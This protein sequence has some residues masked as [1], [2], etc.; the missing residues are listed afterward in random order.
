MKRFRNT[1]FA[2]VACL[3][4]VTLALTS[5]GPKPTEAPAEEPA[6]APA[7]EPAEEPAEKPAGGEDLVFAVVP[8]IA[9]PFYDDVLAGLEEKGGELGVEFQWVAPPT[10]NP[11]EQVQ[12]LEDLINKGVNGIGL[13]PLEASSVEPVIAKA[14]EAGIPVVT[15]DSDAPES[16]RVAYFGTDN[17]AAGY[18]EGNVLAEAIGGKGKVA[19]VTGSLVMANLNERIEGI[20]A[21]FEENYPDIEVV[22]VVATDDDFAKGLET[23]EAMLRAHP[24][25]DGIANMSAT[26]APCLAKIL[27]DPAF[28]DFKEQ[29]TIVAFD[30]FPETLQ[31]IRDGYVLATMVQRPKQMGIYVIESLYDLNTGGSAESV[32]TG[33]TVVTLDNIDTYKG[34]KKED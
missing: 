23:C 1:L 19:L 5:C 21:C 17:R 7:E 30:D 34:G 6:E 28:A 29:L 2:F 22:D 20:E 15:F 11:A 4:V 16:E 31:A 3:V 25:L 13:A 32:D 9:H 10:G 24:D 14:A 33:I 18:E 26:G 8:K 27:A 12:I